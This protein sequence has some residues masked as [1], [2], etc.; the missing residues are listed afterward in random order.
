MNTIKQLFIIDE[1]IFISK[2]GVQPA[3]DDTLL[4]VNSIEVLPSD[5]V[6]EIGVGV[7]VGAVLI[8]KKTQQYYGVDINEQA[9]KNTILNASVNN[10]DLSDRVVVG[11][12]FASFNIQYDVVFANPPQLPTPTEKTRAD[13]IGFANNGGAYGRDVMDKIIKEAPNHI[14]RGG[15]LYLLHFEMI[16]LQK[17]ISSLHQNGFETEVLLTREQPVG[18]LS[19]ERLDYISQQLNYHFVKRDGGFYHNISIL[20]AVK[21]T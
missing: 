13:W 1:N 2:D 15:R 6:L 7:G 8:G 19:F 20:R 18:V 10:L 12:C 17:T 21:R 3:R 9:V 14:K 11:D 16:G 4:L 5:I